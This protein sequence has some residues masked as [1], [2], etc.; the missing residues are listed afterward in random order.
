V[1]LLDF[2]AVS[3]VIERSEVVRQWVVGQ[4]E[5]EAAEDRVAVG[6]REGDVEKGR[7]THS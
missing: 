3:L 2:L 4:G 6:A 7:H 1:C 5:M